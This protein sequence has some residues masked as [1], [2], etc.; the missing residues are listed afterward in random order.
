MTEAINVE[1]VAGAEVYASASHMWKGTAAASVAYPVATNINAS[2][3]RLLSPVAATAAFTPQYVSV[4]HRPKIIERPYTMKQEAMI[5]II[6][7]LSVARID[8]IVF[9]NI[10]RKLAD[11]AEIS[12]KM[13]NVRKSPAKVAPMTPPV[14][15]SITA[16]YRS[17]GF[18]CVSVAKI[19]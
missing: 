11:P 7:Y 8:P 4:P 3:S 12:Q 17:M 15:A 19:P 10:M 13:N 6:K 18:S 2:V 5:T 14:I 1:D 16:K 9:S